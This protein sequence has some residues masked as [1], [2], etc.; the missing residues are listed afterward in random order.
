MTFEIFDDVIKNIAVV[1]VVVY[2]GVSVDVDVAHLPRVWPRLL[3]VLI[4]IRKARYS[5]KMG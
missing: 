3:K 5:L 2:V 4:W 1:V